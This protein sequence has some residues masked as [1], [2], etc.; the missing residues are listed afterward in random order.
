MSLEP[1]DDT[2]LEAWKSEQLCLKARHIEQDQVD[3]SVLVDATADGAAQA[4]ICG[5]ER[6]AG[7]DLSFYED[8]DR[9]A[10]AALVVL[11]FPDMAVLYQDFTRVELH[12]PYKAGFLAFRE[13]PPLLSL[14]QKLKIQAPELWPQI[15]LVDGNGTLHPRRFGLAC[16]LGVLADLPTIG[17]GK[18]FLQI[19]DEGDQLTMET[20]KRTARAS[21]Q[22]GGQWFALTGSSGAVYGAAVRSLDSTQN[23]IF[24]ST[25]HRIA[26]ASAVAVALRCCRY[27]VPEPVRQADQLSRAYIRQTRVAAK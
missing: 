24:V 21:L 16:H 26:L 11:S 23:P 25:G 20:V 13:A 4:D 18:N 2:L 8:D 9:H 17:I 15:L 3:F 12:H 19:R 6:V 10:V 14:L 27:R 1:A 22:R 7:V 5:L